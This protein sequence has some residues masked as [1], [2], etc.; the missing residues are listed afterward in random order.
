MAGRKGRAGAGSHISEIAG[1]HD[2]ARQARLAAKQYEQRRHARYCAIV[3]LKKI[4]YDLDA[5]A[6]SILEI[7]GAEDC[8]GR[9][10]L[11]GDEGAQSFDRPPGRQQCERLCLHI[12]GLAHVEAAP[13]VGFAENAQ[14]HVR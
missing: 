4:G 11:A 1:L 12:H 5:E 2:G 13:D 9:R 10:R 7:A 8:H 14:L 6:A 3:V